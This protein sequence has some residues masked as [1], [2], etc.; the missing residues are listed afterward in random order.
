MIRAGELR[1][2]DQGRRVSIVGR[3][4]V[5]PMTQFTLPARRIIA[6]LALHDEPMTRSTAAGR[7][8]PDAP[9]TQSRSN[10]RRAL[11]QAPDGWILSVGDELTLDADVDYPTA[12]EVAAR[13]IDGGHLTFVEVQLLSE[14]LLPG[15]HEE[16]ATAAQD[17]FRLLRV[18]ALEAACRSMTKAGQHALATQAG[19]AALSA[20]PLSESAADA[21]ISAHLRQGNRFAAARCFRDFRQALR[22]ELGVEPNDALAARFDGL[23][24]QLN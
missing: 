17:F 6:F 14:D 21:L 16:W 9:E 18:Q 24:L 22:I 4:G 23:G 5:Y 8:W 3:L 10:L 1:H 11:W 20:E 15:W 13:A 2:L 7:L 12:R 19:M